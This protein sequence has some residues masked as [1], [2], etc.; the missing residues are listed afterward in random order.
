MTIPAWETQPWDRPPT[1]G[2]TGV[3]RYSNDS[4]RTLNIYDGAEVAP[5]LVLAPRVLIRGPNVRVNEYQHVLYLGPIGSR[6]D[7]LTVTFWPSMIINTGCFS[8]T[9]AQFEAEIAKK[10]DSD[11]KTE[12]LAVIE[13]LKVLRTIREPHDQGVAGWSDPGE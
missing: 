9:L 3:N 1:T 12:Y 2:S 8:G 5:N 11:V 4:P 10:L 6:H 7:T 13:L